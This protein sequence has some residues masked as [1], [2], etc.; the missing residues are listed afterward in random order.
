MNC[1]I[2]GKKVNKL[3]DSI[4]A[5]IK[6]KVCSECSNLGTIIH[7]QPKLQQKRIPVKPAKIIPKKQILIPNYKIV[8]NYYQIIKNAREKMGLSQ[9][10]LA[11]YLGEKLSVI[12]KIEG[13]KL[14]PTLELAR[15]LEKL[16]KV[17][18]IEE[19]S[20]EE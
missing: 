20:S 14:K 17:N 9:D 18:L 7:E 5:G 19:E 3:Y 4:I 10:I 15:K 2:C 6:L 1:E 8:D 16:L 12:K 13:G 11:S